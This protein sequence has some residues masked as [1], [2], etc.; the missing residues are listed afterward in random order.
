ME[1]NNER[2]ENNLQL[3]FIERQSMLLNELYKDLYQSFSVFFNEHPLWKI[4][5]TKSPKHIDL[6]LKDNV[7]I[8]DISSVIEQMENDFT[9]HNIILKPQNH[10]NTIKIRINICCNA[11]LIYDR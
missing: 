5:K 10:N 9:Y 11:P 4:A 3:K 8:Q 1:R 2:E 7:I 6:I